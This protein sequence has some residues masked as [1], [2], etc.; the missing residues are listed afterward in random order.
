M[1]CLEPCGGAAQAALGRWGGALQAPEKVVRDGHGS[2]LGT[3]A[4]RKTLK[5]LYGL[6]RSM[7]IC[8]SD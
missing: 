6:L 3:A 4:T 2:H 7:A 1:P 8:Q 5:K